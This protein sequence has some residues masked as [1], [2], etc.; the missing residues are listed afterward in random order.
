[1]K[2][3]IKINPNNDDFDEKDIPYLIQ[4]YPFLQFFAP[5]VS[6]ETATIINVGKM[7]IAYLNIQNKGKKAIDHNHPWLHQILYKNN[8]DII[9]FIDTGIKRLPSFRLPRFELCGFKAPQKFETTKK[10][11]FNNR[12]NK[13]N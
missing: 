2:K 10:Y 6:P 7:K 11:S 12:R 1:M 5:T 4:Q 8:V 3:L 9:A 13:A